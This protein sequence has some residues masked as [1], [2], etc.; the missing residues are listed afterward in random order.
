MFIKKITKAILLLSSIIT[1]AVNTTYSMSNKDFVIIVTSFNNK[2]NGVYQKN[3]DS[4]FSQTYQNYRV[5]Y[6]DDA[7]TDGNYEAVASYIEQHKLQH[8]IT[9]THTTQRV[10]AHKNIWGAAHTCDPHEII[11]IVDGDDWLYDETV[12]DYLNQ[13]YQDPD[14]W[15]TYGQFVYWPSGKQGY[16]EEIP[17]YVINHNTFREYRWIVSHLR[18]FYA[19]LYQKIQF[20]DMVMADGTFVRRA[21]DVAIMMPMLEMA[22]HHSAF[23][24]KTLYVYNGY[25]GDEEKTTAATNKKAPISHISDQQIERYIRTLEKYKSID[26]P[27]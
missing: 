12:L 8:K 18:T 16:V 13:V 7:S 26:V 24:S 9:L 14:I 22:G 4:I 25:T 23:I 20:K 6:V 21:G 27:F 10:G 2:N 5:I 19:G 3:L 1:I 17:E 15:L 11:V